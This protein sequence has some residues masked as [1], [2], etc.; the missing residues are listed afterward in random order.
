MK[1]WQ[2]LEIEP[3]A[4]GSSHNGKIP[5]HRLNSPSG[6]DSVA[7]GQK[8]EGCRFVAFEGVCFTP[9]NKVLGLNFF[10][11]CSL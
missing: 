8:L 10:F 5:L 11:K 6:A 7:D 1:N 3:K 9:S 2:S 4:P